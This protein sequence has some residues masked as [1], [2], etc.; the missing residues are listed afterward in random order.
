MRGLFVAYWFDRAGLARAA[1]NF[2]K[3]AIQ[4]QAGVD[5]QLADVRALGATAAIW[6]ADPSPDHAQDL[7]AGDPD[8]V[9]LQAEA[10]DGYNQAVM[11]AVTADDLRGQGWDGPLSIVTNLGPSRTE[12]LFDHD[13]HHSRVHM[14]LECYLPENP[15]ATVSNML[16]EAHWRGYPHA[17]PVLG[18][19]RGFG[20]ADYTPLP[21][22][23]WI[24]EASQMAD[25]DWAR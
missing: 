14:L 22:R 17:E 18:C 24:W 4:Y 19:Y 12:P 5:P 15:V 1:G 3:I 9:I 21:E 11:V 7:L 25:T 10:G 2:D 23:Y 13:M 20:L 8:E 6:D 16:A